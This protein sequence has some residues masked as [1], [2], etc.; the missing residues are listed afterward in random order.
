MSAWEELHTDGQFCVTVRPESGALMSP[1]P[2]LRPQS[3]QVGALHLDAPKPRERAAVCGPVSLA[4]RS[5]AYAAA[6]A[7]LDAGQLST[8]DLAGVM[9]AIASAFPLGT[10]QPLGL[11][12]QCYLGPPY[13]VHILDLIGQIVE[14]FQRGRAMPPSYER[15]RRLAAHPAYEFIEVY[16]DVLVCVRGDGSVTEVR[17]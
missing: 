6:V 8:A 5:S 4:R 2:I 13:E 14:H 12:S 17:S 10:A 1:R 16:E 3:D 7:R 9:E 15:A 11:V